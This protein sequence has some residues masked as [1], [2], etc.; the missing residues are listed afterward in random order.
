ML[1]GAAASARTT[2]G[3]SGASCPAAS[4]V[5]TPTSRLQGGIFS[6]A[7]VTYRGVAIGRV[8]SLTLLKNGVR[9]QLD[10]DK[11]DAE[12]AGRHRG[13]R[14]SDRSVIGE[15]YVDPS[16]RMTRRVPQ[17]RRDHPDEAELDPAVAETLL[18]NL[19]SLVTSVNLKNLRTTVDELGKAFNGRGQDLGSLLDCQTTTCSTPRSRT[20]RR[21]SR[22]S[23]RAAGCCRPSS[24]CTTRT[25]AGRTTSTCSA[26][27]SRRATPT[28]VGC[29]TTARLAGRRAH[30]RPGQPHRPGRHPRQSRHAR[31]ADGA[32]PRRPGRGAR[33]AARP[34]VGDPV[35]PSAT[36]GMV[37][38]TTPRELRRDPT[39]GS[40]I[41]HRAAQ[42][43]FSPA[44]PNVAAHC[45][46]P[47]PRPSTCGVPQNVPGG[48]PIVLR[49]W[50]RLILTPPTRNTLNVSTRLDHAGLATR[51]GWPT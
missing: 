39:K 22:S 28:S 4:A 42:P 9:V 8:G 44:A 40:E 10:V 21:R 15:Q 45:S 27:S 7:E 18:Q 25:T 51:R 38:Q 26:G 16:R 1:G 49:R 41:G 12:G 46:A 20:C 5:P 14:I 50:R 13:R 37:T 32:P 48:D 17:G 3:C 33:T 36:L 35:E 34:A 30:V 2:W 11:L 43:I 23:S 29:S 6:N 24:T 31:D 47:R 19:D